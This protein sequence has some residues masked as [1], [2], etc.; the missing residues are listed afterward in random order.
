MTAVIYIDPR[1]IHPV[2]DGAWHRTGLASIPAPG[3]DITML[4]GETATAEFEPLA[5]RTKRNVPTECAYCDVAY[6][7]ALGWSIPPSH[8]GL[9]S[10]TR[11]LRRRP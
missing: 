11:Q 8:P 1:A 5:E 2:F 6:R 4:C 9:Q 10:R 3:E 7:R